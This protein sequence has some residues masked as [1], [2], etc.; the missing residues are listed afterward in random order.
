MENILDGVIDRTQTNGQILHL[1][2][3]LWL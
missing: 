1:K 3:I 2:I